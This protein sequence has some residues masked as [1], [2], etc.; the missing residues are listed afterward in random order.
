MNM[1]YQKEINFKLEGTQAY[2]IPAN[3]HPR[4]HMSKE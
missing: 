2:T 3:M 1:K 4:L